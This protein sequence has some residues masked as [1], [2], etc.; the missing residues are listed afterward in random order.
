MQTPTLNQANIRLRLRNNRRRRRRTQ[1]FFHYPEHFLRAA[2]AGKNEARRVKAK[3]RKPWPIRFFS[4]R[5]IETPKD[6]SRKAPG[7]YSGKRGRGGA[8]K[9]MYRAYREPTFG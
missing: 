8:E 7:N 5:Y 4:A 6:R 1:S 9:F 3:S 2:T